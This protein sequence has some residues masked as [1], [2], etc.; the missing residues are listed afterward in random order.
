LIY[1]ETRHFPPWYFV[2]P[3]V[4][5]GT[6]V[7]LPLIY[8]LVRAFEAET[9]ELIQIVF[10]ARTVHLLGNTLLLVVGVVGAGVLL[11]APLAWVTTRTDLR[12]KRFFTLLGVLPLAIPGYV[13][14]YALLGLSG[15]HGTFAKL[16]GPS[17]PN[18]RGYWGALIA[19]SFYTFPYLFLNLRTALL[20]LDPAIEESAYSLGS[21][22]REVFLRAILPQL[23]PALYAGGLL[24][25]LHVLGDF[26]VVS[27]MRYETFSYALYAQYTAAFDRTYA[28]WLALMLLALTG[29]LLYLEGRLLRGSRF[30]RT[31]SGTSHQAIPISLGWWRMPTYAYLGILT[32]ASVI[33]PIVTIS[34]W[35][36]QEVN[37]SY[38]QDFFR[39]LYGS[40]L[41]STPAAFLTA[42]FAVPLAYLGVRYSSSICRTL[43]RGAYIGYAT[44]PLAFALALI[45]FFR[46]IPAIYQTL[47]ILIYAYTVH[48]LAEAIGP[49]RSALYQASPRLEEAA[50]SLGYRPLKA[51]FKATFPLLR[52]GVTVSIAFVFLAAM[53]ELPLTFLL[54]PA[55]YETLAVNVW[56]YTT[57]A[58]FA[59]G[60]R[61]ALAIVLCSSLFVGLLLMKD[62]RASYEYTE[63]PA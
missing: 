2:V 48:F 3:G 37:G 43:E 4:V 18:L 50:R 26:G 17:F 9:G 20:G 32:L 10:R 11:A 40:F 59:E 39:A 29:S 21:K 33:A 25:G 36:L 22:S 54:S 19:L 56:S 42:G 28:A 57:E 51:F 7:L 8:L 31:G 47:W 14:A 61:Y 6:G 52:S 12:G 55:G 45:F 63:A 5:V 44:P 24:V 1:S 62:S 27:L 41:V 13:M 46:G 49:V 60:A 30:H 16:F 15:P 23:R 35:T 53:K 34:F 58:M 38:T